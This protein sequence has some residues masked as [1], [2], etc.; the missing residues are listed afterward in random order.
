MLLWQNNPT[1]V[2]GRNQNPWVECDV[3]ALRD[4][5]VPLIRR[6]S[7]GGTVYHVRDHDSISC[8]CHVGLG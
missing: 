1:V 3:R 8:S 5:G 6:Y 4:T 7:G 2:I